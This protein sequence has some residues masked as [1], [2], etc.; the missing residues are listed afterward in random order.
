MQDGG[1]NSIKSS[2][3]LGPTLKKMMIGVIGCAGYI[4]LSLVLSLFEHLWMAGRHLS[5]HFYANVW[6]AKAL[7]LTVGTVFCVY[8]GWTL[9]KFYESGEE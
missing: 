4:L 3:I 6:Y 7:L 1:S 9:W 5:P 2:I 8:I